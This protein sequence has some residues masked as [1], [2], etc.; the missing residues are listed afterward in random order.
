M[1]NIAPASVTVAGC[2]IASDRFHPWSIPF[3][4]ALNH[5][6]VQY[7]ISYSSKDF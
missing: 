2:I 7:L 5:G 1:A 4:Q 3:I 6:V